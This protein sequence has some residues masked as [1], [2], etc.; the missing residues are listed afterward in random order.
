MRRTYRCR[1]DAS[2]D[3]RHLSRQPYAALEL[4]DAGNEQGGGSR[5]TRTSDE[6]PFRN[7]VREEL[8]TIHELCVFARNEMPLGTKRARTPITQ[9]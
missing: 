3:S 7:P 6:Q 1:S 8:P 9:A 4:A 5:V 2:Q